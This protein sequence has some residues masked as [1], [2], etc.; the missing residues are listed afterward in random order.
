MLRE[1]G[2]ESVEGGRDERRERRG[3]VLREGEREGGKC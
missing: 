1:R 2:E 3:K